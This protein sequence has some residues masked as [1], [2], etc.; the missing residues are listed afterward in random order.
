MPR[1]HSTNPRPAPRPP[2]SP[3]PPPGGPTKVVLAVGRKSNG[4]FALL[5]HRSTSSHLRNRQ[6]HIRNTAWNTSSF[7]R[8]SNAIFA[9]SGHEST[10]SVGLKSNAIFALPGDGST[11][12]VSRK[13]NAIFALPGQNQELNHAVVC[14]QIEEIDKKELEAHYGF[15]AKIQEVL[16]AESSSTDTLLKQVQNHDVF[17]NERRTFLSNLISINDTYGFEEG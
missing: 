6:C 10:S 7:G 15:M 5:D 17:A 2:H 12:S 13:S 1:L 9:F 4:H 14:H 11:S 16:P 8:K 3:R